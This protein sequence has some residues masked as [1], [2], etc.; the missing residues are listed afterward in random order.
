MTTHQP[1]PRRRYESLDGLRGVA[2][3]I[4]VL[5]H[6]A[7]IDPAVASYLVDGQEQGLDAI[8]RVLLQ[9]PAN[10]FLAGE[11]AVYVFFVL[12]GFVLAIGPARGSILRW[13]VYYPR[14]LVRLYVPSIAALFLALGTTLIVP[15][16]V[17]PM[18]SVWI[19]QHAEG[20]HGLQE[21]LLG[22]TLMIDAEALNTPLWSLQLEVI[23]SILLPLYLFVARRTPTNLALPSIL[24]LAALSGIGMALEIRV[25]M[26]LP[27]FA[28]GVLLA[29]GANQL[30]E[31]ASETTRAQ[32]MLVSLAAL[33][34]I[35]SGATA[36]LVPNSESA[37]PALLM[38]T[39]VG[40]AMSVYI[41]AW[42]PSAARVL[43]LRPV[44]WL[45]LVSFSLYLVHEPII[46]ALA[47]VSHGQFPMWLIYSIGVTVSLAVAQ[48]FYLVVEK[49]SH[50][51][52]R[53]I[54][55]KKA[56]RP[57]EAIRADTD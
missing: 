56:A 46:V 21:A 57:G 32:W 4:V 18:Q 31:I 13:R 43:T 19:N 9:S 47:F 23:F 36:R 53:M 26:Y 39:I 51:L 17:S 34:L 29:Y 48:L 7:L 5:C 3:L 20:G 22:S 10:V 1:C 42:S 12:S 2:A 33:L 54:G 16:T 30:S 41:A 37:A 55:G 8:R 24:A 52:S 44:R 38:A 45:G 11:E 28:V 6:L 50:H 15:R 27:V 35:T 25:L 40:A 49:P 14:R